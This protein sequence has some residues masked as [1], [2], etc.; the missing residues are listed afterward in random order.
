MGTQSLGLNGGI[1]EKLGIAHVFVLMLENRS[2]DH[3]LGFS[4]ISGTDAA[5]GHN[6]K[7]NGLS[8]AESNQFNGQEFKVIRGA[9]FRM[10]NDPAHEFQD[11]VHQLSGPGAT[12]PN[13]GQFP[14]INNSGFVA[15]YVAGGGPV[16][17]EIMKCY[18]PEQLPVLSALAREFVVC[19]NWHASMPGP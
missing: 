10:P 19:D 15:S 18:S 2:F 17:G 9:D 11:V 5:T 4:G 1:A 14:P 7:V 13:A 6:T 16:P 12:Y 3:M 8:G